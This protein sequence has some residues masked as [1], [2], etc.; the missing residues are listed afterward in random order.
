MEK[1]ELEKEIL[2]PVPAGS[3][4][5]FFFFRPDS[6]PPPPPVHMLCF[7]SKKRQIHSYRPFFPHCMAFLEK[8][9][10]ADVSDIFY[11]SP[12][13]GGGRGSPRPPG[14][15]GGRFCIENPR[16]GGGAPG[17]PRGQEGVCGELGIL[18][19]GGLNIFFR[20][21]NV[22]KGR[23]WYW[24]TFFFSLTGDCDKFL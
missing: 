8:G 24:S 17:G 15:G 3:H 22:H 7:Y 18:G 23:D 12:A 9:S 4:F 11:F 13:R 16:R 10:W 20:G 14:G 5:V 2:V 19:G 6:G 21:R 1:H